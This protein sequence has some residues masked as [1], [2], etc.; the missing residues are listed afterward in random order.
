MR[1]ILGYGIDSTRWATDRN[2]C[3]LQNRTVGA[4]LLS[5]FMKHGT[6]FK[7][8]AERSFGFLVDVADYYLVALAEEE[9]LR[10]QSQSN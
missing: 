1:T 5:N 6:D 10:R 3:N 2:S 4:P 7:S 8:A 9:S